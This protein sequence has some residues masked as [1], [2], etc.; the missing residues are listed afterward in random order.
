MVKILRNFKQVKNN[1]K[2]KWPVLHQKGRNNRDDIP[3]FQVDEIIRKY[4]K[5]VFCIMN[6]N[7]TGKYVDIDRN[8]KTS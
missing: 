2:K 8:A 5:A 3:I 4:K 1:R 7:E 6:L